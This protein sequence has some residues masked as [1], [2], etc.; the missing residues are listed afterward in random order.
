MANQASVYTKRKKE[1]TFSLLAAVQRENEKIKT[2]DP[3]WGPQFEINGFGGK[4]LRGISSE[5]LRFCLLYFFYYFSVSK[6]H[7]KTAT[8][9][10]KLLKCISVPAL[11]N[12]APDLRQRF[13]PCWNGSHSVLVILQRCCCLVFSSHL[14]F[15]N[16]VTKMT[17]LIKYLLYARHPWGEGLKVYKTGPMLSKSVLEQQQKSNPWKIPG[18][19][20]EISH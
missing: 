16:A 3:C 13:L 8:I 19:I 12:N 6:L 2:C 18:T 20:K 10:P 15:L 17:H 9:T 7:F 14:P 1:L 5:A 4:Q 11:H